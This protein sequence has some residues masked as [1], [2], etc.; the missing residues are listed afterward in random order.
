[1]KKRNEEPFGD[2]KKINKMMLMGGADEDILYDEKRVI[3]QGNEVRK[4]R[5][6]SIYKTIR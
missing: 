2:G 4:F 6:E 3:S 1:M 5:D